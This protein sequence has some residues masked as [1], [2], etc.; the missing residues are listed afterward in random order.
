MGSLGYA[1]KFC[2]VR[3]FALASL[4]LTCSSS[5]FAQSCGVPPPTNTQFSS[6][7]QKAVLKILSSSSASSTSAD[8]TAITE[9]A[10]VDF[11]FNSD[12]NTVVNARDQLT[13]Q[14]AE[15]FVQQEYKNQTAQIIAEC[16]YRMC[17]LGSQLN[18]TLAAT[19]LANVCGAAIQSLELPAS[20][21]GGL[22]VQPMSVP[23]IF[24]PGQKVSI[25]NVTL[26][27]TG[28]EREVI[29]DLPGQ[30][31]LVSVVSPRT[32]SVTL[33]H[34]DVK[35]IKFRLTKP[36]SGSDAVTQQMVFRNHGNQQESSTVTVTL[37]P[38][39]SYLNPPAI[40][41]CGKVKPN[42]K[43]V[44]FSDD[45][46]RGPKTGTAV[47]WVQIPV[48][49][50]GLGSTFEEYHLNGGGDATASL[51]S[52]CTELTATQTDAVTILRLRPSMHATAGHC[53][54]GFGPGG[55][56]A[57][58]PEW[59]TTVALAGDPSRQH[60]HFS[61]EYTIATNLPARVCAM[62]IDGHTSP[63]T[64]NSSTTIANE[65][66]PGSHLVEVHCS[67]Q[68]G[69]GSRPG[70]WNTI[71]TAD[72]DL[73]LAIHASRINTPLPASQTSSMR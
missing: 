54:S 49:E 28:P 33:L 72:E 18:G 45:P 66:S 25:Y 7:F 67:S 62:V 53:C 58:D 11:G 23:Y 32:R 57:A 51:T 9:A 8:L 44:A 48:G 12:Q 52:S 16:G 30:G 2:C 17:T 21:S 26:T 70:N 36:S 43:A 73:T 34:N 10:F 4:I 31:D 55:E 1:P 24:Q 15:Q 37:I 71:R 69:W 13:L 60:W 38:D 56:A 47:D 59:Q 65:L 46:G 41:P 40:V 64:L 50:A 3:V 61:T 63:L 22:S 19:G 39:K 20:T 35:T 14:Q 68:A 29:V 27:Y 6:N 5:V 42:L